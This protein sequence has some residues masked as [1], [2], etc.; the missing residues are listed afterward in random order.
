M[1]GVI[2][3]PNLPLWGSAPW[4][5]DATPSCSRQ[6]HVR[7]A[8]LRSRTPASVRA[9]AL[10]DIKKGMKKGQPLGGGCPLIIVKTYF[11]LRQTLLLN[12]CSVQTL[13]TCHLGRFCRYPRMALLH[14]HLNLFRR[15]RNLVLQPFFLLCVG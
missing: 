2:L 3:D 10:F 7:S 6:L 11:S 8:C 1:F 9:W 14:H 12:A 15:R 4:H 5:S 13:D